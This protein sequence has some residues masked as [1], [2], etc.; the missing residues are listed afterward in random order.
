MARQVH[1]WRAFVPAL[2]RLSLSRG[3]A[4]SAAALL[5]SPTARPHRRHLGRPSVSFPE[6]SLGAYLCQLAELS[7]Q[8][9]ALVCKKVDPE[10]AIMRSGE[11]GRTNKL[12]D[13]A[14]IS[15]PDGRARRRARRRAP[16]PC[17]PAK[18][19]LM[20]HGKV[21]QATRQAGN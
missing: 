13:A 21:P 20:A 16:S 10:C 1:C 5:R 19:K 11:L 2:H 18:G 15:L 7:K 4:R 8:A 12:P 17:P 14:K 3:L 6:S 9:V